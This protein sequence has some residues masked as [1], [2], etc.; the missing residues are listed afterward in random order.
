M[1]VWHS[2]CD[3]SLL[4]AIVH[5]NATRIWTSF[6]FLVSSDFTLSMSLTC[7]GKGILSESVSNYGQTRVKVKICEYANLYIPKALL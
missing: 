5:H 4:L 3:S 6:H 2:L 1:C 7:Y